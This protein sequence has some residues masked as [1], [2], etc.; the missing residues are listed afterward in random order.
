MNTRSL[1]VHRA[2]RR[3]GGG[4]AAFAIV[5]RVMDLDF[6]WLWPQALAAAA[7]AVV[8]T[9]F[10]GSSAPSGFSVGTRILSARFV[11]KTP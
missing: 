4:V 5:R 10:L 7:T 2:V 3:G 11:I 1:A 6:V 8:V 9:I